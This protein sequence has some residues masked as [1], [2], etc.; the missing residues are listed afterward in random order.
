MTVEL[1]VLAY[2]ALLQVV[3]FGLISIGLNRQLGLKATLGARDKQL[4]MQGVP[5]RLFRAFNNHF[6]ALIL[7]T[8]AVVL[9]TLSNQS[10][11]LTQYCAYTY[12]A[13]RIAYIPAYVSGIPGLRSVIWF[14]GFCATLAMILATLI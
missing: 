10:A 14:V 8:I 9:V 2:A 13:A 4:E 7:F 11:P 6:E 3:Q 1:T 12:L 5:A